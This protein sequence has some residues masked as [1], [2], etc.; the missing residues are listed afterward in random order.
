MG[1]ALIAETAGRRLLAAEADFVLADRGALVARPVRRAEAR[2]AFQALVGLALLDVAAL[3]FHGAVSVVASRLWALHG[4][5]VLAWLGWAF[6]RSAWEDV[7]RRE[8]WLVL[9]IALGIPLCFFNVDGYGALNSESLSELQHVLERLRQP[10]WGYAD[11]FWVDYPTR[12]LLPNILPTLF[13]GISPLAY[14]IGFTVPVFCGLLFFYAGLRAYLGS[15]RFAAA[16]SALGTAML[17]TYPVVCT[18]TRTFEMA[19]SAFAF[20][21]WALGALLLCV[22]RPSAVGALALAW[23]A[24]LVAA[25]FTTGLALVALLAC[26]IALWLVA[27][28]ARQQWHVAT[29]AGG[30]LAYTAIVGFGMYMLR[31][32]VLRPKD[33]S[34]AQQAANFVSALQMVASLTP[35]PDTNFTPAVLVLPTI[36]AAVWALAGRGG[37]IPWLA[38]VWSLGVIWASVNL[39][40]K[41]APELPFVLYRVIVI[42]PVVVFCI[43][44]LGAALLS[45]GERAHGLHRALLVGTAGAVTAGAL[46]AYQ[47]ASVFVP[48]AAP[49]EAEVIVKQLVARLPDYGLTPFSD[50]VV[51]DKTKNYDLERI[52]ALT[53]YFLPGW[54]RAESEHPFF[55]HDPEE[56]RPGI[57]YVMPGDPLIAETPARYTVEARTLSIPV[58]ADRT[59]EVVQLFYRPKPDDTE[60]GDLP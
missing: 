29:L 6:A 39:H 52:P 5:V 26:A 37:L 20:G 40:G 53:W 25:G 33:L 23:T 54:T 11:I 4:C 42:V 15:S 28:A 12:G 14:R 47:R 44:R 19:V 35:A 21:L 27:S 56:R 3:V 48:L 22:A 43:V 34:W 55:A 13:A 57:A 41:V 51:V 38:I 59:I 30:T 18:V 17:L 58:A 31:E 24:G 7:R 9:P 50:A 10:D 46:A 2:L 49:L 32:S 36:L 16:L 45:M 1:A 8:L 60:P